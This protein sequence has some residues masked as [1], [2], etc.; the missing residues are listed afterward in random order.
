MLTNS[1]I[2]L[3]G[4]AFRSVFSA[5]VLDYFLEEALHFPN[6][7]TLSAGAYAALNYVSKQKG[8]IIQTNIEPLKERRYVGLKTFLRTGGLFDMDFLFDQIPNELVPF[9]YET[10]FASDQ[11]L[12]MHATNCLTGKAVY[13]DTFENKERLMDICRASN[14]MPFI[15]PIVKVDEIPLL[16]GGIYDAIPI[17]K[18]IDDGIEKAIVVFTRN[19][20][21][22]KKNRWFYQF[23]IKRVY[24][25]YPR[26]IEV[27]KSRAERYNHALEFV[28]QLEKDGRVYVIRPTQPAIKNS[29]SD[30]NKLMRFY[31]HGYQT[32]KEKFA[33]IKAFLGTR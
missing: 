32:A 10:F 22:R 33:E 3:E 14:S 28:E 6:I 4:G 12:V 19:Q 7:I 13:F 27:V 31:E 26:L 8:R 21:Y 1:G 17:E 18:A 16:D 9:D 15:A 29:E 24:H 20:E 25:K 23:M 2:V 5:G 11:R 30:P